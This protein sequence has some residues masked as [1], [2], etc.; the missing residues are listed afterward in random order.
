[1]ALKADQ[2]LEIGIVV[3]DYAVETGQVGPVVGF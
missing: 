2:V 1:M 3:F